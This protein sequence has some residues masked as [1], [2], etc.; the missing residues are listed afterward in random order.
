M[1]ALFAFADECK[2][3]QVQL[4]P[5]FHTERERFYHIASFEIS[6]SQFEPLKEESLRHAL[7]VGK[8]YT[9]QVVESGREVAKLS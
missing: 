7:E 8:G 9:A 3:S 4:L 5:F 1:N 6:D 2:V